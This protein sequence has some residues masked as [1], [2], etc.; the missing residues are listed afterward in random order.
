[1]AVP[2]LAAEAVIRSRVLGRG[3]GVLA[4]TTGL[5]VLGMDG[6][7]RLKVGPVVHT[8]LGDAINEVWPVLDLHSMVLT[9]SKVRNGWSSSEV[10]VESVIRLND[11][12]RREDGNVVVI[13]ADE[14]GGID[15]PA[16]DTLLGVVEL[17]VVP[18]IE[19]NSER[20]CDGGVGH[21]VLKA[22]H[23]NGTTATVVKIAI[24]TKGTLDAKAIEDAIVVEVASAVWGTRN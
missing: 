20:L 17:K 3:V 12:L 5:N 8:I 2:D 23:T 13:V 4:V 10:L 21:T 24:L 18:S 11:T 7:T 1:L 16:A 9:V 6:T 14:L 19:L 15:P 22:T